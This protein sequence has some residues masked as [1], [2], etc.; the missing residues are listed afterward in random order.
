MKKAMTV[1]L[2]CVLALAVIAAGMEAW[3]LQNNNAHSADSTTSGSNTAPESNTDPLGH[4]TLTLNGAQEVYLEYGE[5]YQEL[6]GK[7]VYSVGDSFTDVSVE[8]HGEVNRFQLGDYS[9]QYTAQMGNLVCTDYR[10]VHVVD[11][12][13]PVISLVTNA[14]SYT[15][16]N[17]FY[18]E[19]GFSATDNH[20]GDVTG[21]VVRTEANGTVTYTVTDSSGNTVTATRPIRYYDPLLPVLQLQDNQPI[22][23]TVGD[24][25][26]DPGFRA[27]DKYDGDLTA[28]VT[29]TGEVDTSKPG[30]YKQHYAVTNRFG[31]TA[32][33]TRTVYVV[34]AEYVP[35]TFPGQSLPTGGVTVSPNGKVIYLTFDDGPS[36]HT[37]KLLD[38]LATYDVKASFFIIQNSYIDMISRAAQ[39]GHTV[40]VHSY[41]HRYNKIYIN[42]DAFLADIQAM[43][44]VIFDYT[45][46]YTMLMRFPGGSSNTVSSAYN[47]GIMSRLTQKLQTMGYRYFDW[48]VDSSDA[49]GAHTTEQ[50][51]QNVIN[52]IGSKRESV[53]LQHDIK[54]Y[55]VD[56][57]ERIIVWGLCN[58]YTFLP[59]SYDSPG[60]HHIVQN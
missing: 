55:S 59:L 1:I 34:P 57:V 21:Q 10:Y 40:A 27:T 58:G 28:S 50:V 41:S 38:V 25:Y 53:V 33:S 51:F 36:A 18:E 2:V 24:T 30:I 11:T 12:T 26:R 29:V 15:L 46:E 13:A 7:A 20:D 44:Q 14:D 19:E 5:A 52:G 31:N 32:S 48:N 43:Q 42:D 16:P 8:I 54:G 3:H 4:L 9:I 47:R 56:A 23:I 35:K 17:T 39:E 45:G 22:V 37:G 49:G 6:S 60:C